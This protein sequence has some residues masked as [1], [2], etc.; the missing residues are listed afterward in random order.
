MSHDII[1]SHVITYNFRNM[2][3]RKPFDEKQRAR[4]DKLVFEE[5]NLF[6]RDILWE[7]L[8]QRYPDDYPA[9]RDVLKYLQTFEYYQRFVRP[10]T[11]IKGSSP[12]TS[13]NP[14]KYIQVD[15][16]SVE[17]IAE[18]GYKYLFGAADVTSGK[19]YCVPIKRKT[20]VAAR[21]A[22]MKIFEDNPLLQP[23]GV[24]SDRGGEFSAEFSEYLA[25]LD[26]KQ[27]FSRAHNPTSNSHIE[28]KWE[29]LSKLIF[30]SL[31]VR[32]SKKWLDLLPTFVNNLNS[33]KNRSTGFSPNDAEKPENIE[34]V[35]RKRFNTVRRAYKDSNKEFNIGD[36]VR[37]RLPRAKYLKSSVPYYSKAI[38]R[39]SGIFKPAENQVALTTYSLINHRTNEVKPGRWNVSTLGGP[40]TEFNRAPGFEG[41]SDDDDDEAIQFSN[42]TLRRELEDIIR[43]APVPENATRRQ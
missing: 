7:M 27:V 26:I 10:V 34:A 14:N 21:N 15:L 25:I 36:L 5:S 16:H 39:I 40:Y 13:S 18:R 41:D 28:L 19:F 1:Q 9:R 11:K 35:R 42:A 33:A 43:T 32:G 12:I 23:T 4:L 30:R 37:I 2:G 31:Y 6:G 3:K 17:G 20:A 24:Q 38:Y 29:K 22:M 8:K